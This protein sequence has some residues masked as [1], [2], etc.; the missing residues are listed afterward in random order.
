MFDSIRDLSDK[1]TATGY[2]TKPVM[3]Q[4]LYLASKLQKPLLLEGQPGLGMRIAWAER[5]EPLSPNQEISH[6]PLNGCLCPVTD[7]GTHA[8]DSLSEPRCSKLGRSD[9]PSKHIA[10]LTGYVYSGTIP[11]VT[12][13]LLFQLRSNLDSDLSFPKMQSRNYDPDRQHR[14]PLLIAP[15]LEARAFRAMELLPYMNP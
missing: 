3:V 9:E 5:F 15:R 11:S 4:V 7:C 1:L 8:Q 12:S 10:L 13:K 2:F 6:R 14:S